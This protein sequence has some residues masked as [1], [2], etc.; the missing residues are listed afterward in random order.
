[1]SDIKYLLSLI[2]DSKITIR[3]SVKKMLKN[4]LQV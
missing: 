1:M 2:D 4:I 3:I